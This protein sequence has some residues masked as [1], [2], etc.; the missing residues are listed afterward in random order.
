MSGL[1]QQRYGSVKQ[2]TAR[3]EGSKATVSRYVKIKGTFYRPNTRGKMNGLTAKN[4]FR[5]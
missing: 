4:A 3:G 2:T 5:R 1:P